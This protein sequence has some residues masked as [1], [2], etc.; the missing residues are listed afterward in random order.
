MA[1]TRRSRATRAGEATERASARTVLVAHS[2]DGGPDQSGSLRWRV[3]REDADHIVAEIPWF[4]AALSH[5]D[6]YA[7]YFADKDRVVTFDKATGRCVE[8]PGSLC[9]DA[10][11]SYYL[12]EVTPSGPNW[13][14]SLRTG[15]EETRAREEADRRARQPRGRLRRGAVNRPWIG[16]RA[17]L[18]HALLRLRADRDP[19]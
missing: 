16:P 2:T 19:E 8:L 5:S 18:E 13:I 3:V 17:V 12:P 4:D 10:L 9:V 7:A 15:V 11:R 6:E 14:G 1:A